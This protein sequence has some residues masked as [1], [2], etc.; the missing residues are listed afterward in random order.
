MASVCSS[1]VHSHTY[2]FVFK[3]VIY[4]RLLLN[5]LFCLTS[6]FSQRVDVV[7]GISRDHVMVAVGFQVKNLRKLKVLVDFVIPECIEVENDSLQ[8][9]DQDVGSFCDQSSLAN[10]DCLLA[11][12]T[13]V[14]VYYFALNHFLEAVMY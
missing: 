13:L 12:I 14:I 2:Q 8:M 5:F 10:I 1:R 7:L 6:W 11:A 3:T 4:D 9:N